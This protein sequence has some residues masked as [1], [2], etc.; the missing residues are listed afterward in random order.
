M[1]LFVNVTIIRLE[2]HDASVLELRHSADSVVVCFRKSSLLLAN[3]LIFFE[4][5]EFGRFDGELGG[6]AA[7]E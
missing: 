5:W 4:N 2:R 6:R 7:I 1:W 3:S